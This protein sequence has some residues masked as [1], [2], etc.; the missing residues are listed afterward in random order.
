M[1]LEVKVIGT[2]RAEYV[3]KDSIRITNRSDNQVSLSISFNCK[4]N[5]W[6]P[7]AGQDIKVYDNSAIL[8]GGTIDAVFKMPLTPDNSSNADIHAICS[9]NGYGNIASRRTI[10]VYYEG[11]TAG[12]I[13]A[14]ILDYVLNDPL[15]NEYIYEG[16]ITAGLTFPIY[17]GICKSVKEIYDDIAE[18]SG[19][20]WYID[21]SK[22]INFVTDKTVTTALYTID[23]TGAFT[24]YQ[25]LGVN[26]DLQNYCNKVFIKGNTD[27]VYTYVQDTAEITLRLSAEGTAYSSGVYGKIIEAGDIDTL[28]ALTTIGDNELKKSAISPHEINVRVYTSAFT[29]GEKVVCYLPKYNINSNTEFLVDEISIWRYDTNIFAYDMVLTKRKSSD[30]STQ[31]PNRGKEFF[32][33][34]AK[35][36]GSSGGASTGATGSTGEIQNYKATTTAVITITS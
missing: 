20:R 16:N 26:E 21:N 13:F 2:D 25:I 11:Q 10:N 18:Q 30:F 7:L 1:A 34:L 14:N 12:Y 3:T 35:N 17:S 24:N 15:N 31:K 8:F 29:V 23:Q 4:S 6:V 9:S 27:G 5:T 19:T 33:A 28:T 22:I 32:E 36:K